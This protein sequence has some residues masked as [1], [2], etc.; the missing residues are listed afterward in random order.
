[1]AAGTYAAIAFRRFALS[2]KRLASRPKP[3]VCRADAKTAGLSY[4]KLNND[5]SIARFSAK[6]T[7][8]DPLLRLAEQREAADALPALPRRGTMNTNERGVMNGY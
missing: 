2:A 1:M 8:D 5:V 7:A 4:R 6:V 3:L